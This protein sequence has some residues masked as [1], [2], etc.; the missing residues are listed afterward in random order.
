M[1]NAAAPSHSM[2]F[3]KDVDIPMND[4]AILRANVFRPDA[5]GRFPVV[6]AQ[7]V[8]GKDVHFAD[9]WKPQ[10]EK[11][12]KLYPELCSNGSTGKYLRWE[13]VDPER[14]VPDGYVVV[15]VDARGSGNRQGSSTRCPPAKS[16]ITSSPSHG[17]ERKTGATGR[18][19]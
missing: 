17:L 11:L 5:P 15:H 3:E 9:G 13:T 6:M 19:G 8:Y 12:L 1:S 10:W 2:L 18:S 7:G 16:K 4:G 14:W